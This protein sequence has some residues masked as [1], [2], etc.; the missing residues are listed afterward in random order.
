MV[1]LEEH[2]RINAELQLKRVLTL[3]GG[4]SPANTPSQCRDVR[5]ELLLAKLS[6]PPPFNASRPNGIS[7]PLF[8]TL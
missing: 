3:L 6:H 7:S 1:I 8:S 2:Y 4:R 5:K